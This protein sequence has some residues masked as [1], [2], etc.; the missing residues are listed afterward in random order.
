MKEPPKYEI[1][2]WIKQEEAPAE[3]NRSERTI[4]QWVKDGKIRRMQPK[5]QVWLYRPDLA[6]CES[7]SRNRRRPG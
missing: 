4:R 5:S 6:Q 7:A 1:K 2:Y 3:V